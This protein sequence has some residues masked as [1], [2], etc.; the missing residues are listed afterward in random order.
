MNCE[1]KRVFMF[2]KS[3][4]SVKINPAGL[5]FFAKPANNLQPHRVIGPKIS[6]LHARKQIKK[7]LHNMRK[8]AM[9]DIMIQRVSRHIMRL[10]FSNHSHIHP[11]AGQVFSPLERAKTMLFTGM[12]CGGKKHKSKP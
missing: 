1:I 7:R 2:K 3:I 12:G 8:G 9:P 6:F 4:N 10:F 11:L 5:Y